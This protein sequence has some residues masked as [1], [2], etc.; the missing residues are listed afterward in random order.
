MIAHEILAF[1]QVLGH[2]DVTYYGDNEP[3]AGQ[4]LRLHVPPGVQQDFKPG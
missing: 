3:T 2:T 4:V 1:T